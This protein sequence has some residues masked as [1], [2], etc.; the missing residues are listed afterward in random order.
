M[1]NSDY[2]LIHSALQLGGVCNGEIIGD[3][4]DLAGGSPSGV[5]SL[6]GFPARGAP[7]GVPQRGGLSYPQTSPK[8]LFYIGGSLI[9]VSK[10]LK[11]EQ[12]GGGPRGQVVEFSDASRRRLI[13]KVAQV[14][15]D[16]MPIFVTLTYPD[17]FPD[18][19]K[20]WARDIDAFRKRF[21]RRGWGAIWKKELKPR[22]SGKSVGKVAPHFHMLVWGASYID[23]IQFVSH[24]WYEVVGSN[25]PDHLSA[26]TRVEK[27]HSPNGVKSYCSKYLCKEDEG[28][29]N[30]G[31]GLGRFWGV[32][33]YEAIPWAV[34]VQVDF[35]APRQVFEL[36]RLMRRFMKMRGRRNLPGL[37]MLCDA[38][39]W[40]DNLHRL[41]T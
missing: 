19:P 31:D 10:G 35:S 9:K 2:S 38:E 8:G 34:A 1:F 7:R 39:F 12:V 20:K 41:V 17:E 22:Q 5:G 4:P 32:I 11:M 33:N 40:F 3:L 25:N 30:Q 29:A 21:S 36:L 37:T 28:K 23:L 14:Q 26:G 18:N 15:K 13:Y 27:I 16:K 6:G 24:A